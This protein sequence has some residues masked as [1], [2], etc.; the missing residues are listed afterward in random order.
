MPLDTWEMGIPGQRGR[1]SVS[2]IYNIKVQVV[3]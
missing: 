2:C 1:L 3:A